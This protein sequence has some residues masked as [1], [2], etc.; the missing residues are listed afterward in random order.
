MKEVYTPQEIFNNHAIE[1]EA[2]FMDLKNFHATF[3]YLSDQIEKVN[4]SILDVGCGP[5]NI[6]KYLLEKHAS[7]TIHG[8]DVAEKM[9][10]LAI[11]NN[12]K[13]TFEL[14][15]CE[16]VLSLNKNYDAIICGFCFPYLS[17][18]KVLQFIKD[19]AILL[20]KD[21]ILYLSTMENN[22]KKSGLQSNTYREH[23]YLN[24][25]EEEYLTKS[26]VDVGITILNT[27]RLPYSKP[28]GGTDTD[29]VIIGKKND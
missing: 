29:L 14:L 26:M 16:N 17:K 20:E 2:K 15:D 22:N 28:D 19:A 10:E 8:I 5:G 21:G 6:T 23:V 18:K 9:I 25:H 3:D 4:P 7:Y 11:K 24:Y 27:W 12:P 13:A 1:Y